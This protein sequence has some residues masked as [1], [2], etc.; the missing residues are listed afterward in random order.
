MSRKH[1]VN[2]SRSIQDEF[3]RA[4]YPFIIPVFIAQVLINTAYAT[5]ILF[6]KT[7]K[8]ARKMVESETEARSSDIIR[9]HHEAR[10]EELLRRD[11]CSLMRK[12]SKCTL[13]LGRT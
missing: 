9:E 1:V 12:L 4:A 3:R 5:R 2:R 6:L 10:A 11:Y 13:H 7:Q 8:T